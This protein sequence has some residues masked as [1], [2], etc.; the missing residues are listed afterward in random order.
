MFAL[1]SS[2]TGMSELLRV[3]PLAKPV[4]MPVNDQ[5]ELKS[6]K[7]AMLG[8]IGVCVFTVVLYIIFW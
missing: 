2:L 8:G 1:F 3:N 4:E 6:S 7:T 5:I